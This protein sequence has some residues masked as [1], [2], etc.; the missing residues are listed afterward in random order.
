MLHPILEWPLVHHSGR[1]CG[2]PQGV[3]ATRLTE[4]PCPVR[5]GS[6]SMPNKAS[7]T[8]RVWKPETMRA[9]PGENAAD[10]T[11]PV[12]PAVVSLA[13]VNASHIKM[14]L[15][16]EPETMRVVPVYHLSRKNQIELDRSGHIMP[17][18]AIRLGPPYQVRKLD[19][20]LYQHYRP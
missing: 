16:A 3:Y 15:S 18:K 14:V 4:L 1:Q 6:T 7:H 8:R 13:P 5:G 11:Q 9:P 19:I 12:C 20:I 17:Y 10:R 2:C